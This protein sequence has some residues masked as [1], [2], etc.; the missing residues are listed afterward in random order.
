MGY[1]TV[2]GKTLNILNKRAV[3][4]AVLLLF[5][6][7][8]LGVKFWNS[9]N[10]TDTVT[11]A[12]FALENVFAEVS[13]NRKWVL[14]GDE[15]TFKQ[16]SLRFS[17]ELSPDFAAGSGVSLDYVISE[18]GESGKMFPEGNGRFGADVFVGNLKPGRYSMEAQLGSPS[19]DATSSSVEFVVSYPLYVTWTLDWEGYDVPQDNLNDIASISKEYG[20][21]VTHFFNPRLYTNP[22]IS[23]ARARYLTDWVKNRQEKG[24][25]IGLHF[26]MFPDMV[27]A[28]GVTPRTSPNWGSWKTDGYDILTSA[29]SYEE[30]IEMLKWAKGVFEEKGLGT[31]TMFRAGGWF[32]DEETLRALDNTGFELDSSGRTKYTFGENSMSGY[33]DLSATTHPYQ[34][35]SENQN[36]TDSPTM[37]LWEF[38]DNGA[39]SW[40]YST[41]QLIARFKANFSGES[42]VEKQV[43][44]HLSHP[45]WFS[46]DRPK[47]EA[48]FTELKRSSNS[49]D[50][51][52]VVYITLEK[53]Y[54]IWAGR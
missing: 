49:A 22:G 11:E 33:W 36:L 54:Q 6:F 50:R 9:R 38:P 26:H 41:E 7:G 17:A 5:P 46:K 4:L 31:P 40:A 29:Y 52:P 47:I 43:V 25:A 1:K 2:V 39:D 19:G 48:L 24:D 44:T 30:T 35:N 51:G 14:I 45:E 12:A 23:G 42:L 15:F 8:Y 32:A 20:V 27:A 13:T 37:A 34:L 16:K 53:A 28:T 21:P 10:T 3:L 18:T